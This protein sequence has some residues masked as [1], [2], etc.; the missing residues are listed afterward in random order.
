M[1]NAEFCLEH[2]TLVVL[3]KAN[4]VFKHHDLVKIYPNAVASTVMVYSGFTIICYVRVRSF[5]VVPETNDILCGLVSHSLAKF[6][7]YANVIIAESYICM[8]LSKNCIVLLTAVLL[9]S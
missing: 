8:V 9:F 3:L 5:S 6:A 7:C 2:R 1:H 4:Q